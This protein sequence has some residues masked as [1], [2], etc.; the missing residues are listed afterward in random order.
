MTELEFCSLQ[1]FG[2]FII[3]C[4]T[5]ISKH[6]Y[7]KSS[8]FHNV[9]SLFLHNL[10]IK[11]QVF[12]PVCPLRLQDRRFSLKSPQRSK[13]P[14]P[15]SHSLPLCQSSDCFILYPTCNFAITKFIVQTLRPK[16]LLVS[17]IA[18][19]R[20]LNNHQTV[21]MLLFKHKYVFNT[22]ETDI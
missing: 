1:G 5:N 10:Y 4:F 19:T 11:M 16:N 9:F 7:T 13:S 12:H 8:Y 15:N 18:T 17:N 20:L 3:K 6:L 2:D 21:K 14:H 22:R